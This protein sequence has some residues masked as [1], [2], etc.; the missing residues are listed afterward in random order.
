MTSLFVLRDLQLESTR[1]KIWISWD[2]PSSAR[3]NDR[4]GSK[5][6]VARRVFLLSECVLLM[7]HRDKFGMVTIMKHRTLESVVMMYDGSEDDEISS[8]TLNHNSISTIFDFFHTINLLLNFLS[9]LLYLI[10]FSIE[11]SRILDTKRSMNN[12]A[13][14]VLLCVIYFALF[15]SATIL[16][17]GL[18]TQ[19]SMGL[20]IWSLIISVLTIPELIIIMMQFWVSWNVK[21]NVISIVANIFFLP[22]KLTNFYLTFLRHLSQIMVS[23]TWFSTLLV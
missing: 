5:K 7:N 10:A 13:S 22:V 14:S 15:L 4:I 20:L 19:M 8:I 3:A 2:Y 6:K 16:I 18:A 12:E 9:Q 11:L 21:W 17:N 23:L 1:C